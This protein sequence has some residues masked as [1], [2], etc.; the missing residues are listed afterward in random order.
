MRHCSTQL[1][2]DLLDSFAHQ[3]RIGKL[4]PDAWVDQARTLFAPRFRQSS[5]LALPQ[6]LSDTVNAARIRAEQQEAENQQDKSGL[7]AI[8]QQYKGL[9]TNLSEEEIRLAKQR[10]VK[11]AI[12]KLTVELK[13]ALGFPAHRDGNRD[14]YRIPNRR[15]IVINYGTHGKATGYQIGDDTP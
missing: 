6:Q 8:I 7:L 10:G 9:Q 11:K 2:S 12:A 1:A 15:W 5:T 3:C 4:K 13:N 14:Y